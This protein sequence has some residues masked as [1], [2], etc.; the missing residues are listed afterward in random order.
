VNV[1]VDSPIWSLAFR[2][3]T[4]TSPEA[5]VLGTLARMGQAKIIGVV[6]QEVLSGIRTPDRFTYIRERLRAFPDIPVSTNFYELAAEFYNTCRSH[7]VQGSHADFLICAV[8]NLK[9]LRIFTTDKDF[10]IYA[11]HLPIKLYEP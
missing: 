8:S 11:R 5:A 10:G 7:G 1:L 3:A 9:R 6:R 2:R 4:A